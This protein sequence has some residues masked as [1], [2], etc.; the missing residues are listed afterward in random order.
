MLVSPITRQQENPI[1]SRLP[2]HFGGAV[3]ARAALVALASV[4]GTGCESAH[5]RDVTRLIE[6]FD[7]LRIEA[8]IPGLAVAVIHDSAVL[9]IT[10]L[11]HANVENRVPVDPNTP[12]NIA[13]VTKPISAT[14]AL[15]LRERGVL[16]LDAPMSSFD[17]FDELCA[18]AKAAGGIFFDDWACDDRR[19]TLRHVLSMTANGPPGERFFYNPV[20]FS[21]ASRPMAQL[22]GVGFSDLVEEL[23]FR[24]V[25]MMRSARI[26][27]DLPLSPELAEDLATPYHIAEDSKLRPSAQPRP[28][29]DGAAGGVI[30]TVRDLAAFDLALDGGELLAPSV[31]EEM[32]TPV[33]AAIPYGLGWFVTN[34]AGERVVWHTGLWEGAYSALYVKVPDRQYTL[35][36]LANSDGLSWESRL[37]EAVL[38]RSPFARTFL[39]MVSRH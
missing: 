5:E 33:G 4:L 12:F 3:A 22:T 1:A 31:R 10:G 7:S 6:T 30:S 34:V 23:V 18:D 14:V 2:S 15:I 28:Q 13:S 8:G 37:D 38:E 17:E 24:P 36:L 26:H 16:D 29:G 19:L 21:W 32:W 20:S 27:R 39:D 25:G 9:E 35:I 11:G